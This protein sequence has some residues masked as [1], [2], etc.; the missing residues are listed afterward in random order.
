MTVSCR[1]QL[2]DSCFPL[3]LFPVKESDIIDKKHQSNLQIKV[4]PAIMVR[5]N[6]SPDSSA[7]KGAKMKFIIGL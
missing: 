4:F 2:G 3:P 6:N 5:G 7:L 1:I